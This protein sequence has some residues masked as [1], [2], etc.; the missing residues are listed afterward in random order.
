M[1]GG[2]RR[3]SLD[4]V[5]DVTGKAYDS[6][7]LGRAS[8]YLTRVKPWL[9]LGLGGSLVRT[10]AQAVTP[11]LIGVT[12]DNFIRTK[13]LSGLGLMAL[14]L[15]GVQLAM[16]GSQYVQTISL[17][18]AGQSVLLRMRTDLFSHLH[19]LS[20]SF[21]DH[22]KVGRLM[23]RVQNDI[24]QLQEVL[25]QGIANLVTNVVLLFAII[26]FMVTMNPRLA[27]IVLSVIPALG[28]VMA[29]WQKNARKF[30]TNSRRA[31]AEVS[32]QIQQGVSGIRV[33]QSLSQEE[34]NIAR[35]D[36]VNRANL[37][38]N[39]NA[40]RLMALMAPTVQIMT[41]VAYALIIIFGGQQ[42]LAGT[43]D[44]GFLVAFL[45]YIQRFFDPV[46]ELTMMY[47]QLQQA[48]AS[49]ARVFELFDVKPAIKDKPGAVDMPAIKG[50]IKFDG[51]SFA[52]EPGVDVLR[53]I[54]FAVNPGETVAVVGRTGAGKSSLISLCTRFYD[55]TKGEITI[56]GLN[57][58]SVTQESLRFKIGIVPQDAF[59][60][61]GT[62]E[63]N[64]RY[65]RLDAGR[66]DIIQAARAAGVHE[67]ITR[68]PHGYDTP[69]GE[70]GGNLSAG[71][72]QL[73]CLAR[74][75]LADPPILILDEAT[76]NVDTNTERIMQESL[77][78]LTHGRTCLVIA[79]RLSTVTNADRIIVL[80]HGKIAEM[81]T[82]QELLDKKGVYY[83]LFETLRAVEQ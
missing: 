59:L 38:A 34:A 68:L 57:L 42:V 47:T 62:I 79:H 69:V 67:F 60:F 43:M 27:L 51:V 77:R 3:G 37:D 31:I 6:R 10:A 26:G 1:G 15:L 44:A 29:I 54:T 49:G 2:G 12:I 76:S 18:F 5:S 20:M 72:R 71:Q 70:R 40:A 41:G 23:S 25:T 17:S 22:N 39:I 28:I 58:T 73:I 14:V 56:D 78:R 52:Y 80:E 33:T 30:F 82:H 75:I 9:A 50:E 65:G 46:I 35:F 55:V 45:L 7:V 83:N 19:S 13:N 63:D 32:D 16:W 74:A 36:G 64:I 81:G 61:A 21:F 4:A 53:D 48:M 11:F 66:E 8:R 24:N